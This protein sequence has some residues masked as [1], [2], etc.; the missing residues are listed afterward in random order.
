ML[1]EVDF[2]KK[3]TALGFT[4]PISLITPSM[5]FSYARKVD[6]RKKLYGILEKLENDAVDRFR[7]ELLRV[8]MT[9][10]E[11]EWDFLDNTIVS[12]AFADINKPIRVMEIGV[13]RGFTA[14]AIAGAFS[15]VELHLVDLWEG[16]YAK[17][18]NPGKSLI[19]SQLKAVGHMGKVF[20]YQGNSHDILPRFF[21]QHTN[22]NFDMII[23]DGDHSL[24]GAEQ[25]LRNVFP[26]IA[27][28][29]ILIFDDIA[30]F[31]FHDLWFLWKH[32]KKVLEKHFRFLEYR[33]QGHGVAVA[34][35]SH[36]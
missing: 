34:I 5:I 20:Y 4:Y 27:P 16:D 35:R 14:C 1:N 32:Y 29:G 24:K 33:E 17:Q 2:M 22:I 12:H 10:F 23:V 6:T 21:K 30:H 26:R 28:G 31:E 11:G 18:H 25:D 8:G 19:A 36:G 15:H 7:L 9:S 3:G 13:R